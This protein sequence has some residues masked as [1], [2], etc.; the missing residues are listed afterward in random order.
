MVTFGHWCTLLTIS[1][2]LVSVEDWTLLIQILR[3]STTDSADSKLV[4]RAPKHPWDAMR[5]CSSLRPQV[6]LCVHAAL[7]TR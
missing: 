2:F 6:T 5:M 1:L 3:D 4:T 7:L